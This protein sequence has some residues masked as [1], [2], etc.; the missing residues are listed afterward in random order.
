[1]RI[2]RENRRLPEIGEGDRFHRVQGGGIVETADI[3]AVG[4]DH[5]GIP[6]VR[7]RVKIGSRQTQIEDQRTLSLESFRVLYRCAATP[8]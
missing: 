5:L 2:W 4:A 8:A 6:H 3:I 1:M 7:F